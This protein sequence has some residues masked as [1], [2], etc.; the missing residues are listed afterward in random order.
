MSLF[1]NLV[2]S[3]NHLLLNLRVEAAAKADFVTHGE[4]RKAHFC[5]V[6]LDKL[7]TGDRRARRFS[8]FGSLRDE[9]AEVVGGI[10][11]LMLV[12]HDEDRVAER[13]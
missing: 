7:H 1:K 6:V 8:L 3:L 5:E 12:F 11:V 4:K 2:G 10:D 13:I 9:I